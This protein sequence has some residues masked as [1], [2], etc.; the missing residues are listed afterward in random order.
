MKQERSNTPMRVAFIVPH[1][2]DELLIGGGMLAHFLEDSAK[3]VFVLIVTN[4]D[5]RPNQSGLRCIESIRAMKVLGLKEDHI[6]FRG[7]ATGATERTF[8]MA[9]RA[10]SVRRN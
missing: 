4:G 8:T 1:Q 7:L 5:Y 6:F 3:E 2:D 10:K 9:P